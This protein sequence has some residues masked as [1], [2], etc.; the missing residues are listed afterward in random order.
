M[1]ATVAAAVGPL[2]AA[3]CASGANAQ[4]IP[5]RMDVFQRRQIESHLRELCATEERTD[6]AEQ[7]TLKTYASPALEAA[8]LSSKAF[9]DFITDPSTPYLDRMAAANR[10]GSVLSVE[11]LP[12]LWQAMVEIQTAPPA[13]TASPCAYIQS[14]NLTPQMWIDRQGRAAQRE[15]V[16]VVVIG[17][18]VISD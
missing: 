14:D 16:T 7:A 17:R 3:I 12:K 13:A 18:L 10:G 8:L 9:W 5:D 11:D 6:V 4:Q 15:A 2:G 1:K